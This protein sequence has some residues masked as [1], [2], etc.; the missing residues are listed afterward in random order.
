MVKVVT[1][2]YCGL[3]FK[4]SEKTNDAMIKV[5]M[6]E[7]FKKCNCEHEWS[8]QVY[9]LYEECP[10]VRCKKCGETKSV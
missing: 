8:T 6:N 7:H 1:C 9:E 5:T 3:E 10:F 4:Y 2:P